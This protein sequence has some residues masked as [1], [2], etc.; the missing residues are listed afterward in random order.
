MERASAHMQSLVSGL[1]D[2]ATVESGTIELHLE[3]VCAS[4][5]IYEW[6]EVIEPLA[7]I[8]R[9]ELT[10]SLPGS[11][12]FVRCDRKRVRQALSNLI[13]N[14]VKFTPEGGGVTYR[15]ESR[16]SLRS[17]R[18]RHGPRHSG[19]STAPYFRPL[20]ARQDSTHTG[21]GPRPRHHQSGARCAR[22]ESQRRKRPGEGNRFLVR[23]GEG[24]GACRLAMR[25]APYA[26]RAGRIEVENL[27]SRLFE[28][29]VCGHPAG[30][31]FSSLSRLVSPTGC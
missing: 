25:Q 31:A 30:F 16:S 28:M 5:L 2:I 9:V 13:G 6:L 19:G 24:L 12:L 14:A 10:G 29:I 8:E 1:L 15:C 20:L 3:R 23:A 21:C 17:S 11:E 27:F 7:R 18:S 4:G 22:R 26:K